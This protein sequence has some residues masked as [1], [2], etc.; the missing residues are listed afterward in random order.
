MSTTKITVPRPAA[1]L[2]LLF[3]AL[4]LGACSQMGMPQETAA[5]ESQP[6]NDGQ[7][8]KVM[9]TINRAELQQAD[10]ALNR[11]SSPE[12]RYL[13]RQIQR[14]HENMTNTLAGLSGATTI[15]PED[16]PLSESIQ[17]Q[18]DQIQKRLRNL[19]GDAFDQAYLRAQAQ[20]H[21]LALDTI[22]ND[23]LPS[24]NEPQLRD[25]LQASIPGFERHQEMTHASLEQI[26]QRR[27][28]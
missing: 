20:L 18:A 8:V 10:M 27:R 4:V 17:G 12:V 15:D 19:D 3:T 1:F 22:R 28:G 13:A 26:N 24:A 23:L 6:L 11:S 7:I 5:E 21:Q 16:S 2:T 9:Q 14:E 25:M